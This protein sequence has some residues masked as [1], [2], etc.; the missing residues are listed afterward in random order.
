MMLL[1]VIVSLVIHLVEDVLEIHGIV[2]NV[3]RIIKKILQHKYVIT[4]MLQQLYK[5][6]A[7]KDLFQP[8]WVV[9]VLMNQKFTT[10]YLLV[11]RNSNF[12][13]AHQEIIMMVQL[14]NNV[15]LP[16]TQPNY[17]YVLS[18]LEMN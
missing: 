17:I 12:H 18:V 8:K 13:N 5:C 3:L 1:M 6:F 14:V 15:Q 10:K 11:V 16:M 7:G 9:N 2:P 4:K